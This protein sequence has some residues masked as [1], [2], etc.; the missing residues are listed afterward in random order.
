MKG[1][2]LSHTALVGFLC[3]LPLLSACHVVDEER[4]ADLAGLDEDHNGIRDDVEH[5]IDRVFKATPV[6]H[7][8]AE[9]YAQHLQGYLSATQPDVVRAHS[10]ELTTTIDCLFA[11]LPGQ[12]HAELRTLVVD[13]VTQS[14]LN[15]PERER[16]YWRVNRQVGV[17]TDVALAKS[18][19]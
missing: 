14:T 18:C 12:A 7:A 16:H 13:V 3:V 11:H 8:Y 6:A 2:T 5:H 4:V 19:S 15:T 9:R 10:H 1:I 17:H